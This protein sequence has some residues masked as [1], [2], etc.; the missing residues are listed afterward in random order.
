MVKAIV[1]VR[2]LVK[3]MGSESVGISVRV[4]VRVLVR[5]GNRVLVSVRLGL[6]FESGLNFMLRLLLVLGFGL[7]VA[8]VVVSF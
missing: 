4:S 5:V 6:A 2:V 8:L 7:V 1:S 3:V